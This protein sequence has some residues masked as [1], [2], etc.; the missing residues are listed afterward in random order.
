MNTGTSDGSLIPAGQKRQP[1]RVVST[2]GQKTEKSGSSSD[3]IRLL[4]ICILVCFVLYFQVIS[5]GH[6]GM[7][8]WPNHTF[9]L[10]KHEQAVNKYF[11]HILSL[12]TDN[13]PS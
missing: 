8:S 9:F 2:D 5:Y 11:V 10:G 7:V 6:G 4:T 1:V 13:N 3:D 12:A